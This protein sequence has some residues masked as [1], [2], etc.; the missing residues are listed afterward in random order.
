[1]LSGDEDHDVLLAR[2][3]ERDA[4]DGGPGSDRATVDRGL[5]VLTSIF[6]AEAR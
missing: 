1:V 4:V 5:D 2:D 3:D 6:E